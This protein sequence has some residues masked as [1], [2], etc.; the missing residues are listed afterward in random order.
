MPRFSTFFGVSFRVDSCFEV[1]FLDIP[2]FKN[3]RAASLGK[4]W[5]ITKKIFSVSLVF[6]AFLTI[7]CT[8]GIF[9]GFYGYYHQWQPFAPYLISGNLLWV[10]IAAAV[11]NI[12]PSAGLGRS[13]HTGRILFHHY[14]YGFMVLFF[15][16]LYVTFFTSASLLTLFF[17][18][19]TSVQINLGRFFLLGGLTLV[20]DDLPD[21]N[22]RLDSGLNWLKFKVGQAGRFVSAVQLV[23]GVVSFYIF[24]AVT[25]SVYNT[26]QYVT[27]ANFLVIGSYFITSITSFIF[28]R[29]KVWQKIAR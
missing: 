1:D 9:G 10:V 17:V 25:V 13:L 7:A 16:A 11:I 24:V 3:G 20:L 28:V 18:N 4:L 6:N 2:P 19:D 26:P 29:R 8:V 5:I 15:S 22:S 23:M 21:V 14:F 27:V 12:F